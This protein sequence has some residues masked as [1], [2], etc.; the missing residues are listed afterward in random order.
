MSGVGL[1]LRDR[2]P[3]HHKLAFHQA[4]KLS[5]GGRER[6]VLELEPKGV[7]APGVH[8]D[9][10]TRAVWPRAVAQLGVGDA[11]ARAVQPDVA[12]RYGPSF[13]RR[14]RADYH[15]IARRILGQHIERLGAADA[16]PA[17]L[18]DG[19]A[20]LAAVTAQDGAATIDE[21]AWLVG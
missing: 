6:D 1:P 12:Q 20:M 9:R 7:V 17:A 2:G 16:D 15:A 21:I 18:A 5:R 8:T 4:G 19:E 13:E 11:S 3:P 14:T 10:H